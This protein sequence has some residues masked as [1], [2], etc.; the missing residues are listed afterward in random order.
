[1]KPV[2]GLKKMVQIKWTQPVLAPKSSTLN[3]TLQFRAVNSTHWVSY[4]I[5]MF[6]RELLMFVDLESLFFYF[7]HLKWKIDNS[8]YF[9]PQ[10]PIWAF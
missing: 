10:F 7:L 5:I 9:S 4:A 8:E 2:L 3:Y 1:M 6:L